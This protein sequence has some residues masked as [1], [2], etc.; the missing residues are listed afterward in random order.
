[1]GGWPAGWLGQ[2]SF[3]G[4]RALILVL[5]CGG[6]W[7]WGVPRGSQGCRCAAAP[8]AAGEAYCLVL[9]AVVLF[10]SCPFLFQ[11]VI[12]D[13]PRPQFFHGADEVF[14]S[15]HC[16]TCDT[17]AI[18]THAEVLSLDEYLVSSAC[19]GY[20]CAYG[21]KVLSLDEYLVSSICGG[22]YWGHCCRGTAVDWHCGGTAVDWCC[23]GAAMR[24]GGG[25]SEQPCALG[26][27]LSH[28]LLLGKPRREERHAPGGRRCACAAQR[29]PHLS[30]Y[31][32]Y[33]SQSHPPAR[34]L[35]PA[36]RQDAEEVSENTFYTRYFYSVGA[37]GQV[38]QRAGEG[39]VQPHG[40]LSRPPGC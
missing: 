39:R 25:G 37:S 8:S 5:G 22:Y 6:E 20:C 38:G 7:R 32:Q 14:E 1:M 3:G 9:A 16:D 12:S 27:L 4:V 2:Q 18:I 10:L 36:P 40:K 17:S 30:Q 13:S 21:T 35:A 33:N 11:L 28:R 15:D 19:G 34:P 29:P 26:A 23:G 31:L 24:P